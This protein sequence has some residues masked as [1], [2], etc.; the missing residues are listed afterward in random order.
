MRWRS[1]VRGTGAGIALITAAAGTLLIAPRLFNVGIAVPQGYALL[2]A[3]LVVCALLSVIA[4]VWNPKDGLLSTFLDFALIR[5]PLLATAVQTFV[6]GVVGA[7]KAHNALALLLIP[8]VGALLSLV[9]KNKL[10]RPASVAAMGLT[11]QAGRAAPLGDV[12]RYCGKLIG[13]LLLCAIAFWPLPVGVA[14]YHVLKALLMGPA[15]MDFAQFVANLADQTWYLVVV[16]VVVI[17][18]NGLILIS[19]LDSHLRLLGVKDANRNLSLDE[20]TKIETAYYE[21]VEYVH[22]ARYTKARWRLTVPTLAVFLIAVALEVAAFLRFDTLPDIRPDPVSVWLA[23][24]SN[25][26]LSEGF[27]VGTGLAVLVSLLPM[28]ALALF[29][30][31]YAERC[32]WARLTHN[33]GYAGLTSRLVVL[34]RL[35]RLPAPFSA[36]LFLRREGRRLSRFGLGVVVLGA[37]ITALI[38][39][40]DRSAITL[41]RQN[42]IDVT[43]WLSTRHYAFGEVKDLELRC[44][45]AKS[46]E[47]IVAIWIELPDNRW[48]NLTKGQTTYKDSLIRIDNELRRLHTPFE[49][50]TDR[51]KH[52]LYSPKCVALESKEYPASV[53]HLDDWKRIEERP[54]QPMPMAR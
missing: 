40:H 53:L 12:L 1:A 42:G 38:S 25:R 6:F 16:A 2:G 21:T 19:V 23:F 30:T 9:R 47:P 27:F 26:A 20:I 45:I 13:F 17:A 46:G 49:F 34:T 51:Q 48:L 8:A 18:F 50:Y 35:N 10:Y 44:S 11:P 29:W 15:P 41:V 22:E 5:L 52:V 14:F 39:H 28:I 24:A 32:G 7:A 4:V 3:L 43:D 54:V 37:G 36:P 31:R 33:G